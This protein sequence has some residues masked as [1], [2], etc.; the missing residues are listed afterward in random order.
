M[1]ERRACRTLAQHRFT[2]CKIP[3]GCVDETRLTGDIIELA[4]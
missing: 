4:D 3:L 1:S 2:Q